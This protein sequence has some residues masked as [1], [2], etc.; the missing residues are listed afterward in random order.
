M[1]T[2]PQQMYPVGQRG[3]DPTAGGDPSQAYR[4]HEPEA[5]ADAEGE[6]DD[7]GP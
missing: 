5:D 7:F 6:R 4:T 3:P 1:L 2:E